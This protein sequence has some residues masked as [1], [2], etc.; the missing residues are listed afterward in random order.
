[1]GKRKN[2]NFEEEV[3][4]A[5]NNFNFTDFMNDSVRDLDSIP[6]INYSK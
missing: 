3:P 2:Y 4:P 5:F 6:P 1:M